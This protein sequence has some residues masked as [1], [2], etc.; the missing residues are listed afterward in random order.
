MILAYSQVYILSADLGK[1]T[2]MFCF[3]VHQYFLQTWGLLREGSNITAES[4]V[5]DCLHACLLSVIKFTD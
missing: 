4:S 5:C 2:A 3:G 1:D